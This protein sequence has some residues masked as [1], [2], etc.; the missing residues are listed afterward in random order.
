MDAL[1]HLLGASS[2]CDLSLLLVQHSY[3]QFPILASLCVLLAVDLGD[4][5]L[6][7]LAL[8]DLAP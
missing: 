3:D 4:R 6:G 1:Q 8:D 7:R 5:F 2:I